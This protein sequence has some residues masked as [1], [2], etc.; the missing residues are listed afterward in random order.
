MTLSGD[1]NAN[2]K[3][4]VLFILNKLNMKLEKFSTQKDMQIFS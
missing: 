3:S 4:Y 2:E 1:V